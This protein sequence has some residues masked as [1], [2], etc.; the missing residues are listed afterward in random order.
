VSDIVD[1]ST[2]SIARE[3]EPQPE[4]PQDGNPA[5]SPLV[6]DLDGVPEYRLIVEQPMN[7]KSHVVRIVSADDDQEQFPALIMTPKLLATLR[8]SVEDGRTVA[9]RR[10]EN[11]SRLKILD[12]FLEYAER[13]LV[14]LPSEYRYFRR[15]YKR[16]GE[17]EQVVES[18][19]ELR[20]KVERAKEEK[21]RME[22]EFEDL[23]NHADLAGIDTNMLLQMA[24]C[25]AGLMVGDGEIVLRSN[26]SVA[27]EFAVGVR[28]A[29]SIVG[30]V[31]I[32]WNFAMHSPSFRDCEDEDYYQGDPITPEVR[33]KGEFW[34]SYDDL[35]R[36]QSR[37]DRRD[38]ESADAAFR[39]R[40]RDGTATADERL[41]FDLAQLQRNNKL[42]RELVEAEDRFT[43]AKKAAAKENLD[44][45]GSKQTSG[46]GRRDGDLD[47]IAMMSE[48][49]DPAETAGRDPRIL[50][51]L[52][53]V[54]E[55]SRY[56]HIDMRGHS[57]FAP[58]EESYPWECTSLVKPEDSGS[59]VD[60]GRNRAR[61]DQTTAYR[62][63]VRKK[64]GHHWRKHT[65]GPP[66]V[67]H[68][69][70]KHK[71]GGWYNNHAAGSKY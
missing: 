14:H 10:V 16:A 18:F 70:A 35:Q 37:F 47:H 40:R 65:V 44:L 15:G 48:A 49:T 36:A 39:R 33:A 60:H 66:H 43:A 28:T 46:F 50:A 25:D 20:R 17:A 24:F 29:P 53:T 45:T 19:E 11:R 1:D 61:I 38:R 12:D 23:Q 3:N 41:K 42:T 52:T 2:P 67:P 4:T 56:H 58:V 59:V 51:W 71:P 22:W 69:N 34:N 62:R 55:Y 9:V 63:A 64:V 6:P 68:W 27:E 8:K 32:E 30:P 54:P 7:R 21:R 57:H 13:E 26:A 5:G 31:E